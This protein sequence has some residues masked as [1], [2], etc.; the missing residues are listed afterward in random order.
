[1]PTD[2]PVGR[3]LRIPVQPTREKYFA[4]GFQKIVI[5]FPD[6][7]LPRGA[8]RDRHERWVGCGGREQRD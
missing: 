7:A 3:R 1:M 8:Y 4:S 2:L 6:P 5:F